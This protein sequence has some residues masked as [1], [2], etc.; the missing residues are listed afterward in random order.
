MII[1]GK[2]RE[3]ALD[4][5]YLLQKGY[6]EKK[7]LQLV[8]ENY[9]LSANETSMLYRGLARKD[10]VIRRKQKMIT[11]ATDLNGN[12]LLIDG[13]N[14]L[15]TVAAY[16]QGLPVFISMDGW[17]RDAT[18]SRGKIQKI[19]K[20]PDAWDFTLRFLQTLKICKAEFILENI[21]GK[22]EFL[23]DIYAKLSIYPSGNYSMLQTV[24]AD[25][26]LIAAEGAVIC[27]SDTIVI[28]HCKSRCFD[29]AGAVVHHFF[30]P[31]LTDLGK[32]FGAEQ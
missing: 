2:F 7:I 1:T 6:K 5:L 3:A 14:V 20:L 17:V 16:L 22:E 13:W 24:K 21:P 31:E 30:S 4:Y 29:L 32:I 23:R 25:Q 18:Y 28:D 12:D 27:T 19:K 10:D 11:D 26:E 9:Q 8:A 15:I